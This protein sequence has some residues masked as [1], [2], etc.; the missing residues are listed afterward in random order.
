[1]PRNLELIKF[2]TLDELK[3]LIA[4][5]TNKRDRSLFLIAYR[6][7]PRKVGRSYPAE[8]PYQFVHGP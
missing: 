5:I 7:G 4:A 1:M 6:H 8:L 2:P 3:R